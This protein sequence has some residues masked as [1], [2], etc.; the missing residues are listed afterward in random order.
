MY[1][2][3][4]LYERFDMEGNSSHIEFPPQ[5]HPYIYDCSFAEIERELNK[6]IE[7]MIEE[8]LTH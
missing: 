7:N 3:S 8:I 5:H 2:D 6:N 4:S 1:A